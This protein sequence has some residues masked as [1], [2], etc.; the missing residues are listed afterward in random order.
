MRSDEG[1]PGLGPLLLIAL[2]VV[3]AVTAV[4]LRLR[5]SSPQ[6]PPG[7]EQRAKPPTSALP[8]TL[9]GDAVEKRGANE[10]SEIAARGSAATRASS[11]AAGSATGSVNGK[12]G[13]VTGTLARASDQARGVETGTRGSSSAARLEA[14]KLAQAKVLYDKGQE[15]LL[16]GDVQRA[17]A[18]AEASLKLRKTARTYLLRAQAEQRL[19]RTEAA[20]A[21]VAA[22]AQIAP[23]FSMVWELRG[24]ILWAARRR[25]EARVAFEKFLR[26]DPNSSKA[27]PIR[28]LMNDPR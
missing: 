6:P 22:A 27:P 17:L 18:Q 8:P 15:A 14:E 13:A 24:R 11:L 3:L 9:E 2:A 10:P 19:D 5:R 4:V 12:T 21:S 23:E 25:E 28:R 1:G 7:Q 26:L 16:A 20:L